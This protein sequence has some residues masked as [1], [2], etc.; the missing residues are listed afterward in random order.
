MQAINDFK[1]IVWDYYATHGRNDLPWRQPEPNGIFDPYKI[2]VS[3]IMLQQTQVSRV[4]EKYQT[5]LQAFPDIWHLSEANFA[6]VLKVWNGLGYN[7]RANFLLQAAKNVIK[8]YDGTL[9]ESHHELVA[10]PGIGPNTAAAILVYAHNQPHVFIETNIR[11][12]YIYHFFPD[13]EVVH[14]RQLFD[15]VA[16]TLDKEHPREWYW[17]LM[18]YGTHLKSRMPNP[19]RRS[20]H[21]KRQSKFEGSTRQ[22]RAQILRL[23][24][25]TSMT[26][27][28]ITVKT[29]D[30][31]TVSVMKALSK[32][33][34][35]RQKNKHYYLD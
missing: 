6:D 9:P 16:Q 12:I 19:G 20:R 30:D 1:E 18:D 26:A 31:R 10:L 29:K 32:E 22:L 7:R 14:D 35:I 23:L 34:L 13:E 28:E 5:F 27:S 15:I 8:Q 11:S 2:M 17:A 21:Y 3:E 33:G 4:I 25:D 24:L